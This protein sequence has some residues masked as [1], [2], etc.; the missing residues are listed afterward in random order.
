MLLFSCSLLFPLLLWRSYRL[1]RGV[2]SAT[3]LVQAYFLLIFIGALGFYFTNGH[4]TFVLISAAAATGW[5]GAEAASIAGRSVFPR[6]PLRVRSRL[7]PGALVASLDVALL[8]LLSLSAY[9]I[10]RHGIGLI[11]HDWYTVTEQQYQRGLLDRLSYMIGGSGLGIVAVMHYALWRSTRT[12]SSRRHFI[13]VAACFLI[14]N[15]LEGAKS[16]A[17]M[18]LL[19]LGIAV[20]Y[21][22]RGLPRRCLAGGL[23]IGSLLLLV[24]G[25]VWVNSGFGSSIWSLYADRMTRNASETFDFELYGSGFRQM[26]SP[27]VELELEAKRILDQVTGAPRSPLFNEFIGNIQGGNPLF[28]MT[29]VSP[30]LTLMGAGYANFG[31]AGAL[32]YAFVAV[33]L[34]QRINL[35]LLRAESM[36]AL[37][38]AALVGLQFVFL[39]FMR[40]G[41]IM[42]G[43]ESYVLDVAVPLGL[44]L[45]IMLAAQTLVTALSPYRS[46][47]TASGAPVPP[48]SQDHEQDR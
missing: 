46:L 17:I 48:E 18:P 40:S 11:T 7:D 32:L 9:H 36:D 22:H 20:F 44:V 6:Q 13:F 19:L 37:S 16:A 30:E 8:L 21:V 38:F 47:R 24:I 35:R 5:A 33:F 31:I 2:L 27:G 4:Y 42:I 39:G 45:G 3:F 1:G 41:A 12:R 23:M 26:F 43:L 28:Q 14:V 34:A 29:G 15:L 10:H 25:G